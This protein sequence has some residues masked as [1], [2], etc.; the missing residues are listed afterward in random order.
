MKNV[1]LFIAKALDN[2]L[3]NA[4]VGETAVMEEVLH[5][6]VFSEV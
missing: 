4:R 2:P 6:D 5:G 3:G 1:A